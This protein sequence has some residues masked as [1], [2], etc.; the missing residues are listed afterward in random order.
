[1]SGLEVLIL[2]GLMLAAAWAGAWAEHGN[3]G[4]SLADTGVPEPKH[5]GRQFVL[6]RERLALDDARLLL[7]LSQLSEEDPV[8]LAVNQILQEQIDNAVSQ[9]S[10]PLMASDAGALAHTAGGIEWLRAALM[11]LHEARAGSRG[12]GRSA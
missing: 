5:E 2:A 7:A 12:E 3:R 4:K 11:A 6:V 8:W 9:V 1:M 10:N